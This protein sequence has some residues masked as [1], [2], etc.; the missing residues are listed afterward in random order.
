VKGL[1]PSKLE[2]I[3]AKQREQLRSRFGDGAAVTFRVAIEDGKAK[4]KASRA[5]N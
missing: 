5:K 1:T 2:G 4:L 3:L